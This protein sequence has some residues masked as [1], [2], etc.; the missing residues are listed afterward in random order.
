MVVLDTARHVLNI[1]PFSADELEAATEAYA[2]AEVRTASGEPI[3]AVLVA[4]GSVEQLRK[5]YPNYFL[6][7]K[8]FLDR[9]RLI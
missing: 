1:K 4:G 6:D 3:D 5:T 8:V 9:L 2:K 7:A